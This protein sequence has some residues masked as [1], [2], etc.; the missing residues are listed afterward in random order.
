MPN[1]LKVS[2][3]Y[4]LLRIPAWTKIL[5]TCSKI[6]SVICESKIHETFFSKSNV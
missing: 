1:D 2:I 5:V 4:T 6:K 3:D